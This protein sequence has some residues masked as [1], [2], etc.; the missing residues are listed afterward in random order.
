MIVSQLFLIYYFFNICIS[1]HIF[2]HAKVKSYLKL[3]SYF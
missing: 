3:F 1:I 2:E